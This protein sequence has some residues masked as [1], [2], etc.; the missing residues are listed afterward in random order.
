MLGHPT[1]QPPVGRLSD[2]CRVAATL[3][4]DPL[5][6]IGVPVVTLVGKRS[7]AGLDVFPAPLVVECAAQRFT[8]ERTATSPADVPVELLDE[9]VV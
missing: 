6:G 9:V 4:P 2:T 7:E 3:S 1:G 5:G 8:D